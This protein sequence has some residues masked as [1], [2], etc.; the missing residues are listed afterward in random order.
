MQE[1]QSDWCSPT[2]LQTSPIAQ[3]DF[4]GD[5]F[6]PSRSLM[7]LDQARSLLTNRTTP[8]RSSNFND[9]YRRSL[10]DKLTLD[11]DGNPFRMLVFRGSP[12]SNRKPIRSVDLMRQ[13]EAK[14][15]D[16]S[17]KNVQPRRLPKGEARVLDAVN[18]KNDFYSSVMDWGKNSILAVALGSDLFLWN[19]T[20]REVHKLLHVDDPS[21]F[22]TS[23]A[24]S[25]NAKTLAVGYRRSK[26]Q[27]WDAE[28]SKLVRRFENH[29]DRIATVAWNGHVL[30]SGS[31]DTSIINHDVRAGSNVASRLQAHKEEVCGLKWSEG[32]NVLASGGNDN[33]LYI[34][35][36]SKMNSSRF[37]FRFREHSAAVKALAWCPYQS[38]VCGLEWNR[39]HKEILSA[40]GYSRSELIKNQLCIWRYPSMANVGNLN[41]HT[42]RILHV[43]QSPDGL[44]VVSAGGDE[45]L[46]FW[47]IFGP[48]SI[49]K[50]SP[51]DGLLSLKTSPLR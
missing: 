6:I 11:S 16:S 29:K 35:D 47:E 39:H 20:N 23:V 40:H 50:I 34:W 21:D 12:K 43:S 46:R 17:V 19:S 49:D 48:P 30:T 8:T 18:I 3:F 25:E 7:D 13:D 10:E 4:P 51:L 31:R 42:S 28:T 38:E 26:L 15:L 9:V 1:L 22:P 27:L 37:L 36:S 33:L 45:T 24:W 2:R 32:G 5:R 14:E 41:R 44:T